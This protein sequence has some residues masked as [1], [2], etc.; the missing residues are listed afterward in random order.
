MAGSADKDYLRDVDLDLP[1]DEV[2]SPPVA[3]GSPSTVAPPT[4]TPP[5]ETPSATRPLGS[6]TAPNLLDLGMTFNDATQVPVG[7]L[8]QNGLE[9][10]RVSVAPNTNDLAAAQNGLLAGIN[11][12][13]FSG[14]TL[15]HAQAILSDITAAISAANASAS[16]AGMPGAEQALRASH[17]SIVNAV[18]TD[19][20]LANPAAQNGAAEPAAAPAALPAETTDTAPDAN[21]AETGEN[22]AQTA[23]DLDAA[24]AEMEALIAAN[25]DLF[26]GLTVDDADEIVQQIQLELAK[27]SE[28]DASGDGIID[29]VAGDANLASM[30]AQGPP[31][32][33]EQQD[34][35][36]VG[37]R[38]TEAS[39]QVA[40]MTIGDV[41]A[42]IVTTE[43][44][45]I[46]IDHGDLGAPDLANHLHQIWG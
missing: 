20:V 38:D 27:I 30:T 43:A 39:P 29:V 28:G 26:I 25:P 8:S 15:G 2:A 18:N 7:D 22:T 14:A 23:E 16:S 11:A 33:L 12:G 6:S 13:Q 4:V 44:P 45:T 37:S 42:T 21:P 3:P 19:P 40:V 32:S 41:T 9:G 24:I 35:I 36:V 10:S 5:D 34:I 31:N 1:I 46:A 17:L